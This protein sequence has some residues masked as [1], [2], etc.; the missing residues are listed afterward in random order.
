MTAHTQYA[1]DA[2]DVEAADYLLKPFDRDRFHA[3]FER[4]RRRV[5]S[6]A[7]QIDCGPDKAEAERSGSPIVIRS[8]G[9]ILP[10]DYEEI[11]WIES[12]VNYARLHTVRQTHI[13]RETLAALEDRLDPFRFV[14]I[15]RCAIVNVSAVA[16][17]LRRFH[18]GYQIRLRNGETLRVGRTHR[19]QLLEHFR[20]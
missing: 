15:H 20:A 19:H 17:V 3:A 14:R 13:V 7:A 2:F 5:A 8:G 16:E 18:G 6:A 9:R 11:E 1:V 10:I 4:A 12:A